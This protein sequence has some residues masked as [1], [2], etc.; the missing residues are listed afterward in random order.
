MEHPRM[1]AYISVLTDE[2]LDAVAA[3]ASGGGHYLK[4]E[5]SSV[6]YSKI[7]MKDLTRSEN[8]VAPLLKAPPFAS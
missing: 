7:E 2:E 4:V 6:S 3:G 1:Q 8:D 5:G